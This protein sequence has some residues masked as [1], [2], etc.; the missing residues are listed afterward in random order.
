MAHSGPGIPPQPGDTPLSGEY[1]FQNA[2]L[3]VFNGIAGTLTSTGNFQGSLAAVNAQGEAYVPNF[4]L[5][6]TGTPVPLRT[7]F[8]VL[9]DGTN[10]NTILQ[11][12]HATLGHTNFTTTGAVI[13][14]NGQVQRTIELGVKMPDGDIRDLL[15]LGAKGPPF[16]EGRITLNTKIVIPPLTGTVKEKLDL[17]G[18]FALR[19]AKFLRSNIEDQLDQLSRRGQG[20][21]KNEEID[22]VVAN[23]QG[24]FH[25]V[26]QTMTFRNLTFDVPGANIDLAGTYDMDHDTVDFHGDLKL[27]AK[28]SE[29][30][31]GWKHWALKPVDPLFAK[32]GAG[33]YLRIKVEGDSHQPKFGLDRGH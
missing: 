23:M 11:P 2:D 29:T 13:K 20:Q 7:H 17:D 14:K 18:K 10:G 30:V 25:L 3:G 4:R 28:V 12:V 19:D 26:N 6:M 22:Q 15:R 21:P 5:K 27:Q 24:V 16:M 1:T 8:S 32:H 33:T 9:V 31:T